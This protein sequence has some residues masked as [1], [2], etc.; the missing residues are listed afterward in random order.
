MSLVIGGKKKKVGCFGGGGP[1]LPK[2][3]LSF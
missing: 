2:G 3:R 1:G